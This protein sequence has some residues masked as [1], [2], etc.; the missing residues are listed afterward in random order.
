LKQDPEVKRYLA[1][2][3]T[4]GG[5]PAF[6]IV[7]VLIWTDSRFTNTRALTEGSSAGARLPVGI[8]S[9][10]AIDVPVVGAD[11]EVRVSK[12]DAVT[13]SVEATSKGSHIFAI[14]YKTVQRPARSLVTS[15]KTV[16]NDRG[17]ELKAQRLSKDLKRI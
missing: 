4:P 2:M 13:K 17:R 16:L 1:A 15:F 9:T 11:P 8:F 6:M 3:L 5:K 14:Q 12:H 7:A 10:A